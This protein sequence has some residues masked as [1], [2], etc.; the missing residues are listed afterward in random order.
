METLSRI[1]ALAA[2][3][4]GIDTDGLDPDAPLDQLGIDSLAF[5]DFLFKVEEEFKISVT[6]DAL[7]GIKTL[8]DLERHVSALAANKT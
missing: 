2:R 4:L 7:K 5:M 6:D 3:E 1:K 8:A